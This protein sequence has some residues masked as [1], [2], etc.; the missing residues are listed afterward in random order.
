MKTH[1][2]IWP[3]EI[4]PDFDVLKWKQET[5]FQIYQEIKDLTTEEWLAYLRQS[6]ERG[7]QRRNDLAKRRKLK[8]KN[9]QKTS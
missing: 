2:M 8:R 9:K 7:E 6:R 1:D 3:P 4:I 5:Q